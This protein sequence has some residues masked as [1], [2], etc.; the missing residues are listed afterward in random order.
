[1]GSGLLFVCAG[2]VLGLGVAAGVTRLLRTM[3]V[4]LTAR[5]PATFGQVLILVAMASLIACL[6][7][8]VRALKGDTRVG[9]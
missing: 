3:L 5:D 8:A 6:L 9:R 7:P 1:M 4:G 2:L